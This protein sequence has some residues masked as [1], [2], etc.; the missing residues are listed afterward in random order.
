MDLV[1]GTP[2]ALGWW[3]WARSMAL[4]TWMGATGLCGHPV[5]LHPSGATGSVVRSLSSSGPAS[6]LQVRSLQHQCREFH[7]HHLQG[8]GEGHVSSSSLIF[9]R[10]KHLCSSS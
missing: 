7:T 1:S 2:V 3:H 5:L 10:W 8:I 4:G 9:Q 6:V